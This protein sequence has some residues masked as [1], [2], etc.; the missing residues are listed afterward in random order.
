[1][2]SS[3]NLAYIHMRLEELFGGGE[4]FG[5][6]NMLFVNHSLLVVYNPVFEK[7]ST[8]LLLLQLGC[9]Y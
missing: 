2:V 1:M 3:L 4:W 5:S 8:K 7:V 6:K 9:V